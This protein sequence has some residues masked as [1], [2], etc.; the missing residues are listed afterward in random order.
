[1]HTD[2]EAKRILKRLQDK[3]EYHKWLDEDIDQNVTE[4]DIKLMEWGIAGIL[5][6]VSLGMTLFMLFGQGA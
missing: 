3:A 4:R 1:M 2:K 5:A 6:F